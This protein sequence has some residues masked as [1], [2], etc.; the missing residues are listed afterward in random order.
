MDAIVAASR[1]ERLSAAIWE[2]LDRPV[3]DVAEGVLAV[4]PDATITEIAAEYV[5]TVKIGLP[6]I[7]S[8]ASK[9]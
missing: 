7:P 4:V 5:A 9:P 6:T 3:L 8:V 1:N 2:T